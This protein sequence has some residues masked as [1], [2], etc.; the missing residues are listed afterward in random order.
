LVALAVV[1]AALATC[2]VAPAG[3]AASTTTNSSTGLGE[4]QSLLCPLTTTVT[5]GV[6]GL[7]GSLG[8][9]SLGSVTTTLNSTLCAL[10][11]LVVDYH[12]VYL[13]PNGKT[14]TK[15]TKS[16]LGVDTLLNVN[17]GTLPD[18]SA[19]VTLG[20]TNDAD[21]ELQI[22]RNSTSG[23]LP[24]EVEAVVSSAQGSLGGRTNLA[25]GY[26]A[27]SSNAPGTFTLATPLSTLA[28]AN[29]TYQLNLTQT[30]PGSSIALVGSVFDGTIADPSDADNFELNYGVSPT[31][32][33]VTASLTGSSP[34][35]T[36]TTS[37]P[38]PVSLSANTSSGSTTENY[39]FG[40]NNL[41]SSLSLGVNTSTNG[42][43][44]SAS[45][46]VSQLTATING[47]SAI[48]AGANNIQATLNN[49]PTSFTLAAAQT[50][51]GGIDVTSTSAI[52]ELTLL[53][54]S[55]GQSY[56]TLTS[57]QDSVVYNNT[58]GLSLGLRAY[59]LTQLDVSTDPV[60]VSTAMAP[61]Y[62][63]T[64]NAAIAQ[65]GS[66]AP[67]QANVTVTDMPATL[68]LALNSDGNGINYSASSAVNSITGEIDSPTALVLGADHLEFTLDQLPTSFTMAATQT[69]SG[70]DVSSTNPIG[71][72]TLL[73][74]SDSQSYP[75]LTPGQGG[76]YYDN[77]NGVSLGLQAYGFTKLDYSSDPVSL[78]TGMAAG[79]VFTVDANLDSSSSQSAITAN[80]TITDLPATM[81]LAVD[82]TTDEVDYSASDTIT[83]ITGQVSSPTA[84]LFGASDIDFTLGQLP[85]SFTLTATDTSG[86]IDIA[87]TNPIGQISLYAASPGNSLPTPFASNVEGVDYDNTNGLSLALQVYGLTNL[88]LS[89]SPISI[90]ES[91]AGGYPFSVDAN[92]AQTDSNGNA[93]SPISAN[94]S[95]SELPAT[96]SLAVDPT[97]DDIDYSASDAISSITG[98]VNSPTALFLGASSLQFTL[99]GL[100]TSF[101]LS[102]VQG[103]SGVNVTSTNPIGQLTLYAASPGNSFPTAFAA[104]TEGVD[105]DNTNGLS[106]GVQVYGLTSLGFS[107]SPIALSTGTAGGYP[108]TVN[109]NIAQTDSS[110]N[111]AS[112]LAANISLSELPAT[113]SL[114][115]DPNSGG[116]DY[117]ASDSIDSITGTISSPTPV[118]LGASAIQLTM[119]NVPE[120]V[121]V[122]TS[123]GISLSA[124][125]GIGTLQLFA[126]SSVSSFPSIPSGDEG[127]TMDNTSGAL[128]LGLEMYGVSSIDY[129]PSPLA[130]STQ[131]APGHVFGIQANIAQTDSNGNTEAPINVAGTI[132]DLPASFSLGIGSDG[133]GGNQLTLNNSDPISNLVLA[134]DGLS[135]LQGADDVQVGLDNVPTNVTVGLPASGP[136]ATISA[137]APIGQL[138][139][140]AGDDANG[141]VTLPA[142]TYTANTGDDD[143]LD[144]NDLPNQFAITARLTGVQD[145]S[146]G[147]SPVSLN[148]TQDPTQSRPI[149]LDAQFENSN[150]TTSTVSGTPAISQ[151]SAQTGI[152]VNI[153]TS[154]GATS[155]T[156][157]NAS[158]LAKVNLNATNLG[159]IS[160]ANITLANIPTS[161]SVCLDSGTGCERTNPTEASGT[162]TES[163]AKNGN[164]AGNNRP[165]PAT[166]SMDF[167]DHGTSG[168]SSATSSMTDL[169]ASITEAGSSSPI[170]ITNLY[171]HNLE[172]DL[173]IPGPTFSYCIGAGIGSTCIGTKENVPYMYMYIDSSNGSGDAYP[174]VINNIVYPPTIEGFQIGTDSSPAYATDRL[175]WIQGASGSAK[176]SLSQ[177][178][179]GGLACGGASTLD[180]STSLGTINL[181]RPLGLFT[182]LNICGGTVVDH[183]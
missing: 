98:S 9:S 68:S 44:Y 71:E 21:L 94:L 131:S 135:L 152:Q 53:A 120:N 89:S 134:A 88:G 3:A 6:S 59:G 132:T 180:A 128:S 106:L 147:D 182:L 126:G 61:G 12:T 183:P 181:I 24:V 146:F 148:L 170:T 85:T 13:E 20:G 27:L 157:T 63:F 31:S 143:E 56:P 125:G 113:M 130:L 78:S 18:M 19:A 11:T 49:L 99:G 5:S 101:K 86:G 70:L 10:D 122:D 93:E 136:V 176:T 74:R 54:S 72:I 166:V 40:I 149:D 47:S 179:T 64:V 87:S 79:H 38:G 163:P 69:S 145:A 43:T 45:A 67:L 4:L 57:G 30:T 141:P 84:V 111:P 52:G 32:A 8:L 1:A 154:G 151:P 144:F 97:S 41:P 110:G 37:N 174:F 158:P 138:L 171:F 58:N 123:N 16:V 167:D 60:S 104:N 82:P 77:T 62:V 114:T 81:S 127:V 172:M 39:A 103:S 100:P 73:A 140:A 117:S 50:S 65:S 112:P 175:Y 51:S 66:A 15:D 76:I 159:A 26:N 55:A 22:N 95:M 90:S 142:D 92:I 107:T 116:I 14:I 36:L 155:L 178:S 35:V 42:I 75:S 96:L 165:Y 173:A 46:A 156:L 164:S 34:S 25:V 137:N 83:S 139:L 29:N 150:G 168:A 102:A 48:V 177:S 17:N 169:N 2:L 33:S 115:V 119:D 160:S 161:L 80:L 162:D 121:S 7:L 105:Y 129:T 23:A 118:L 153:P 91:T 133:N 109:A 124:P 108:F 28:D